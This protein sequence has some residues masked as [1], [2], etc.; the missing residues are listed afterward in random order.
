MLMQQS[1]WLSEE[2]LNKFLLDSQIHPAA[3]PTWRID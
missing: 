3:V 2:K 1:L